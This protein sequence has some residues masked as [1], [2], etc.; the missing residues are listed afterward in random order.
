MVMGVNAVFY[1]RKGLLK[2]QGGT[3]MWSR[4][5]QL[6][7]EVYAELGSWTLQVN[8]S[9]FKADSVTLFASEFYE[10]PL[11]GVL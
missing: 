6:E 5:G 3:I 8:Q 10:E 2:A 11:Q 4:A 7:K 9:N 1:P